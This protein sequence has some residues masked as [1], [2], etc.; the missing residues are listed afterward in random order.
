MNT[1]SI[2]IIAIVMTAA[3]AAIAPVMRHAKQHESALPGH[4][5]VIASLRAP[6]VAAH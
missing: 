6:V 2:S 5:A 3:L 4:H 1:I